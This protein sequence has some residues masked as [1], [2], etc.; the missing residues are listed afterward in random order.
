F[1][2]QRTSFH[3]SPSAPPVLSAS[4]SRIPVSARHRRTGSSASAASGASPRR[5]A[6]S[7]DSLGSPHSRNSLAHTLSDPHSDSGI[8][9]GIGGPGV[10]D[11]VQASPRLDP[12]AR[13][14]AA[15]KRREERDADARMEAF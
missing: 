5:S 6:F 12:E 14:L 11:G 8:G 2:G 4:P 9:T 13:Q 10:L 15:R 1:A 3:P 7:R